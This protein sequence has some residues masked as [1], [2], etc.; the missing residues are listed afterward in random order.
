MADWFTESP[1]KV[2][3]RF[4]F[5]VSGCWWFS[6]H[7]SVSWEWR[8]QLRFTRYT[9]THDNIC[10]LAHTRVKVRGNAWEHRTQA[11]HL[12]TMAFR[13]LKERFFHWNTRSKAGNIVLSMG[14]QIFHW[15]IN[16]NLVKITPWLEIQ[17]LLQSWKGPSG[18]YRRRRDFLPLSSS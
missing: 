17:G 5:V 8:H 3:F 13:G 14:T 1:T 11:C 6:L 2:S 9:R 16:L 4:R 7:N 15:T 12:K 18:F 10:S